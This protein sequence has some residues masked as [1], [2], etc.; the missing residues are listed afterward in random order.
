[1]TAETS[2]QRVSPRAIHRAGPTPRRGYDVPISQTSTYTK[3]RDKTR[4]RVQHRET[5]RGTA[6]EDCGQP[7]GADTLASL[8]LRRDDRGH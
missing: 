6:L 1:M 8:R 2:Q 7:S 4:L 5:L 3:R